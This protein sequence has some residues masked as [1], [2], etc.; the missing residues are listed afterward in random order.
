MLM[1]DGVGRKAGHDMSETQHKTRASGTTIGQRRTYHRAPTEPTGWA[2]MAMFG[3]MVMILL[4]T[5][6]VIAGLLALL[7]DG[8][9]VVGSNQLVVHA[10]YTAW[11]WVHIAIGAIAVAAGMGL[12]TGSTWARVLGVCVCLG[13]ALVNFA[14]INAAPFWAFTMITLAVLTIYAITGHGGEL[15][16]R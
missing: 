14:F 6:Q 4:G 7:D 11:G 15:K 9:Y 13:S 2:G 5:F 3:A 12:M 10:D 8:Y 16:N 1:L